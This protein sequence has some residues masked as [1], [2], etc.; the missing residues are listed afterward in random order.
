VA[1]TANNVK[2]NSVSDCGGATAQAK[3]NG[4]VK[5]DPVPVP[6]SMGLAITLVQSVD[7]PADLVIRKT[8][9]RL[10]DNYELPC[11]DV[12]SG[13]CNIPLCAAITE[14]P[15]IVCPLLPPEIPCQC[16]ILAGIYNSPNSELPFDEH[17]LEIQ[18]GPNGD[19]N[20]RVEFLTGNTTVF[21]CVNVQFTLQAV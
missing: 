4:T 21:G 1:V 17:W 10:N 5:T 3:F 11:F 16:P 18:G 8:T 20:S 15:E 9:K 2:I 12:V 14:A 7:S 19:Y 13:T 6:G